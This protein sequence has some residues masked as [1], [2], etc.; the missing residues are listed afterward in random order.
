[1]TGREGFDVLR[2][3]EHGQTCYISSE[4]VEGRILAGWL[5]SCPDITKEQLFFLMREA[6]NQLGMIQKCRKKPYYQYV[7]PY[8]MVITD[9]RRLY[10]LDLEAGSNEKRLRF[11]Q[12]RVVRENFLPKEEAYYQ[13]GSAEIDV[14]GLGKTFQYLLAAAVPEPPLNRREERRF[15]RIISKC[16]NYQSKSSYQSAADIRRNIPQYKK[17]TEYS[18]AFRK[19]LLMAAGAAVI[20]GAAWKLQKTGTFGGWEEAFDPHALQESISQGNLSQECLSQGNGERGSASEDGDLQDYGLQEEDTGFRTKLLAG[21]SGEAYMEVA[22]AYILDLENYEKSLYYLDKIGEYVPARD[23]REIA[24]ALF[25]GVKEPETLEASL[26][27]LEDQAFQDTTGQYCRC[28]VKGY[29]L[30]DTKQAANAILRLGK[31][32]IEQTDGGEEDA[33]EISEYIAW[34][35][36]KTGESAEAARM[37]EEMLEQETDTVEREEMYRKIAVLYE[38]C[39][40]KEKA[41]ETCVRGIGELGVAKRLAVMHIRLMCQDASVGRDLCAQTIQEYIRQTPEILENEEFQKLQEEYG[42]QAEGEQVWAGR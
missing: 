14:Y 21:G 40:Q 3:I 20:L 5:K 25:R 19:R 12:R 18:P 36:E 39:G 28:L 42:I 26:L 33:K 31:W 35:Y 23:L 17:K 16:L 4:Y 11:M 13:R 9:E 24:E 38:E 29:A 27:R 41:L 32:Y 34:A 1:M 8:S 2:L 7:N 15:L 6:A 10:F 22:L 37:Y 30:L